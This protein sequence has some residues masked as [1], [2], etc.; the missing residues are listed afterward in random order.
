MSSEHSRNINLVSASPLVIPMGAGHWFGGV[1][2]GEGGGGGGGGG[3]GSLTQLNTD[4]CR[5]VNVHVHVDY[6]HTYFI[7]IP[8][9]LFREY[10]LRDK[11]IQMTPYL[12]E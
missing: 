5:L 4:I 6:M 10:M 1:G 2:G 12:I 7:L 3:G 11:K 9:R 8:K